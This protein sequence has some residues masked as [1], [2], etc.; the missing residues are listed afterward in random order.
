MSEDLPLLAILTPPQARHALALLAEREVGV[1]EE[2]GNNCGA[3]IR[4]YQRATWLAPDAWPWCAAF[5]DW[6]VMQWLKSPSVCELLKVA[7]PEQWRPKTA[8]AWDLA[9]WAKKHSLRVAGSSSEARRGDIC[10]FDFSGHG[11]VGIVAA[12]SERGEVSTIDGN[13]NGRGER[14]SA[15]GDGVW[16]KH[17]SR[18]LVRCFVR[19][20]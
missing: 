3:K 8:G 19:L 15:T 17:R 13:T 4:E 6:C 1:R 10:I 12:D 14:D 16:L 11:H 5:V 2:G 9:S 18:D 7:E 20:C